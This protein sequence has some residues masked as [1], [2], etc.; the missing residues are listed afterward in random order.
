MNRFR[1][2]ERA[3]E[4]GDFLSV[5]HKRKEMWNVCVACLHF[6]M[7]VCLCLCLCLCFCL[8]LCVG[9]SVCRCVHVL[10]ACRWRGFFSCQIF[11]WYIAHAAMRWWRGKKETCRRDSA[12]WTCLLLLCA[13]CL[14]F[15]FSPN[16]F[17]LYIWYVWHLQP[18]FLGVG[19]SR[20]RQVVG[21]LAHRWKKKCINVRERALHGW[22][23]CVTPIFM[24]QW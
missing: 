17:L 13:A 1:E 4:E 23:L 15:L 20:I 12:F 14:L 9:F 2:R 8:S 24:L 22:S 10:P 19:K 11:H 7:S 6:S 3:R 18:F 21:D 5:A 16:C